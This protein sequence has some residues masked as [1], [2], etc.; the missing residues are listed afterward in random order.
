MRTL[1]NRS[2]SHRRLRHCLR[3][4]AMLLPIA[5][6][7]QTAAIVS[8]QWEGGSEPEIFK[9]D[10]GTWSKFDRKK[11]IWISQS[12]DNVGD[13]MVTCSVNIDEN[14]YLWKLEG[15]EDHNVPSISYLDYTTHARET[16]E[17]DRNDGKVKYCDRMWVTGHDAETLSNEEKSGLCSK[18]ADPSLSPRPVP[19]L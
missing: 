15:K 6:Q 8:C 2:G 13:I 11:W 5:A 9:I 12:C 16:I 7:A 4:A 1:S 3:A 17:I 14:R 10:P 18:A 19:K